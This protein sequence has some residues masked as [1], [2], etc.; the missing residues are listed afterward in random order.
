MLR[1]NCL[2]L[3]IFLNLFFSSWLFS[4]P[5][6]YDF[7][8]I[9]NPSVVNANA[10]SSLSWSYLNNA[11]NVVKSLNSFGEL[12]N[13]L[14][15]GSYE[16]SE[17]IQAVVNKDG[18]WSFA[19]HSSI[20]FGVSNSLYIGGGDFDGDSVSDLAYTT[21]ACK[22]GRS[23]FKALMN[24][25]T[26]AINSRKI[27]VGKGNYFK[28]FYDADNDGADEICYVLPIKRSGNITRKFKAICKDVLS[29]RK[30]KSIKLGKIYSQPQVLRV[31]NDRDLILINR[32]RKK[33]T[34]FRVLDYN[35]KVLSN[36]SVQKKGTIVL[37]NFLNANIE[38]IAIV[39]DGNG[40]LIH[41]L[42]KVVSQKEFPSGIPYD[43][44]NFAHFNSVNKCFC[45]S[46]I[47]KKYGR[48]L[49]QESDENSNNGNNNDENGDFFVPNNCSNPPEHISSSDGFKCIA[50][51]TR[52]N[53]VVCLLPY[54]FTWTPHVSI[55]DHH[56]YVF[57]CNSNDESFSKVELVL[58]SGERINLNYAG[59][60]N[61]VGTAEGSIGRQHFRNESVQW[62]DIAN[63]VA[64]I[65]MT[66]GSKKT[67]LKF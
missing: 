54:Q 51:T 19:T 65:E 18:K 49:A 2:L 39:E 66:K 36:I 33:K 8:S 53:S 67:C 44:N 5:L 32:Q 29:G 59:C 10:D 1:K 50:S 40:I 4:T 63:S 58:R 52:N 35:G 34:I 47:L 57:A 30:V 61:F 15:P 16:N 64:T 43:H 17:T 25:L 7:D 3:F 41:P 31:R 37:G 42:T 9:S 48:C 60:H 38:D 21:R 23:N 26:V 11:Q 46:G 62:S 24:P 12:G 56:G 6:D 13:N 28:F 14:M 27:R 45:D 22:K 20:D 55:T